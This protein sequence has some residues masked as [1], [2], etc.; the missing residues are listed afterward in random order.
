MGA[1]VILIVNVK[2]SGRFL[3]GRFQEGGITNGGNNN[4]RL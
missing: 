4:N 3:N 2:V 1:E